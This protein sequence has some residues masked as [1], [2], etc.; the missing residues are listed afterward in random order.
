MPTGGFGGM[1][2]D[3]DSQAQAI[4][5]VIKKFTD[6]GIE[7]RVRFG[8]EMNYYLS[9][10]TYPGG[11]GDDTAQAFKTAW[12]VV[13]KAVRSKTGGKAKMFFTPNVAGDTSQYDKYMPDLSE[14]DFVSI[15]RG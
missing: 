4:A 2:E 6:A 5:D 13:T 8:H 1:T 9:D 14:I 7:V 12:S 15:V 3:D 11:T 10:G